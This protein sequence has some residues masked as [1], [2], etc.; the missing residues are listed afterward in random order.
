MQKY[1]KDQFKP[2]KTETGLKTGLDWK[3]LVLSGP[4]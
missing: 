1:L 3:R 2:V 4:V